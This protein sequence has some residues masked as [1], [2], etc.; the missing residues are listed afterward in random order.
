MAFLQAGNDYALASLV[1][2]ASLF[3]EQRSLD[4]F[5]VI[6]RQ[7]RTAVQ[8]L[9]VLLTDSP[10]AFSQQKR[11]NPCARRPGHVV[12]V[13]CLAHDN[14]GWTRGEDLPQSED[15]PQP[16]AHVDV[17]NSRCSSLVLLQRTAE[18]NARNDTRAGTSFPGDLN[19]TA[20]HQHPL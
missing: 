18:R 3:R 20:Q 13:A 11:V 2:N 9:V 10:A 19:R 5:R 14:A 17:E 7:Q 4:P 6:A 8:L 1:G 12:A 16:F 15:P